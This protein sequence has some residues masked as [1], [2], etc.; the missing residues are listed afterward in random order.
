ME[1]RIGRK[2]FIAYMLALIIFT[3]YILLDTFVITR[4]YGDEEGVSTANQQVQVSDTQDENAS[5]DAFSTLVNSKLREN[6]VG[7]L[8]GINYLIKADCL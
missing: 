3:V 8:C 2:A 7:H 4:V 6:L 5:S 1:G